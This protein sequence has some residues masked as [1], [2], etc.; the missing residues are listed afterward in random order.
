MCS[1][2]EEDCMPVPLK[3][4]P[5]FLVRIPDG[6]IQTDMNSDSLMMFENNYK[7]PSMNLTDVYYQISVY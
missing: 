4:K 5:K 7:I 6:T 2:F 1:G 3:Y